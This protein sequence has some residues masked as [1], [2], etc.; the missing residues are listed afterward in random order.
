[1][2]TPEEFLWI[3]PFYQEYATYFP[4]GLPKE[5]DEVIRYSAKFAAQL[6]EL[7]VTQAEAIH[8]MNLLFDKPPEKRGEHLERIKAIVKAYRAEKSAQR[9][10]T[11]MSA[12]QLHAATISRDCPECEGYGWA[13]RRAHHP[14][15][16]T[17]S[18]LMFCRCT[19]GRWRV[20]R[21]TEHKRHDLQAFPELWDHL[22]DHSTWSDEPTRDL[23]IVDR[24]RSWNYLAPDQEPPKAPRPGKHRTKIAPTPTTNEEAEA[25]Q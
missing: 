2:N 22:I 16:F 10:S 14:G 25:R 13:K 6:I 5:T 24:N 20:E 17:L 1:M 8:A 15:L 21:D 7:K 19:H 9:Q 12:D 23:N 11:P 18:L 3:D 4:T